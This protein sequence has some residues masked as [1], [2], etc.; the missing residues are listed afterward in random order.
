MS[1]LKI[2]V[3]GMTCGGCA[4]SIQ[5]ALERRAEV[6]KAAVDLAGKTASVSTTLPGD[7]IVALIERLGFKAQVVTTAPG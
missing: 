5:R 4:Q 3:D 2:H 6:T 1:D 7:E